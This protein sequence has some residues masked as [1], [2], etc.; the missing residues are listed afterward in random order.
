MLCSLAERIVFATLLLLVILH[1][2]FFDFGQCDRQCSKQL[3]TTTRGTPTQW[4]SSCDCYLLHS[5]NNFTTTNNGD[6]QNHNIYK[7]NDNSQNQNHYNKGNCNQDNQNNIYNNLQLNQSSTIVTISRYNNDTMPDFLPLVCT[8][9]GKTHTSDPDNPRGSASVGGLR[10]LHG[11]ACGECSNAQDMQEYVRTRETLTAIATRCA[12]V[13][14]LFGR[15]ASRL[16]FRAPVH[17][18]TFTERCLGCWLNNIACTSAHCFATCVKQLLLESASGNNLSDGR[19]NECLAC[20]ER[21]CGPAFVKCAGA[22]RRRMGVRTDIHRDE[23]EIWAHSP[24]QL[25]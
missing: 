18:V 20:D 15:D 13:Y 22:N 21:Y 8:E 17:N 14:L 19:L 16:C 1:T 24:Q 9:D 2:P 4:F 6:H 5:G 10:V 3:N 11:G 25:Q 12:T 7:K 23:R